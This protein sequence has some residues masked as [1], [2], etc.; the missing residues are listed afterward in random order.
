MLRRLLLMSA[1]CLCAFTAQAYAGF[2]WFT[3]NGSV[4]G[5]QATV[6]EQIVCITPGN[7]N[8]GNPNRTLDYQ[9]YVFNTGSFV[10]DGFSVGVGGRA[11]A[12]A[13]GENFSDTAGGADGAF[14]A[15]TGAGVTNAIAFLGQP[16]VNP[17]GVTSQPPG[18][19][20]TAFSTLNGTDDISTPGGGGWGF[21]EFDNFSAGQNP[22]GKAYAVRWYTALQ[23]GAGRATLYNN[24]CNGN[25]PVANGPGVAL[26]NTSGVL[27]TALNCNGNIFFAAFRVDLFSPNSPVAG[28]GAPDPFASGW[29]LSFDDDINGTNMSFDATSLPPDTT[30]CDPSQTTCGTLSEGYDPS[31]SVAPEPGA[32]F[33]A[34][35][36]LL[37]LGITRR[38]RQIRSQLRKEN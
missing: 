34:G 22:A 31:S 3:L 37:A 13:G 12:I 23:G 15:A 10:M 20:I 16:A 2:I 30:I 1:L 29:D 7:C 32:F 35:G 24:G 5:T 11:A 18:Q 21:E 38:C 26:N 27:N 14:P 28:T 8:A 17:A 4:P 6:A 9:Y 19:G 33:L 25:I 36:G